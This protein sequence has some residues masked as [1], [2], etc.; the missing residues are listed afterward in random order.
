MNI[1][2]SEFRRKRKSII[3]WSIATSLFS[4]TILAVAPTLIDQGQELV[5]LLAA[6]P[7]FGEILGIQPE[8]MTSLA[9]VFSMY[10]TMMAI[11]FAIQAS[12]YGFSL[13]SVEETDLTADFLLTKPVRRVDII[14][15][16]LLASLLALAITTLVFTGITVL[17]VLPIKGNYEVYYKALV[18][19]CLSSF[20]IQ[21]FFFSV[22]VIVSLCM[23]RIKA[24][25]P[26]SMGLSFGL[27]V[28]NS[29][30][31]TLKIE[32]MSYLSPFGYFDPAAIL[33]EG[34]YNWYNFSLNAVIV[35]VALSVSYILYQKRD[36][37]SL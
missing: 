29:F 14:T 36:I 17:S 21:L 27:F 13:V 11:C 26:L 4:A 19:M 1:F 2:I 8:T 12:N 9:G 30:A 23:K 34:T 28:V 10:Y 37:K 15:A 18:L 7:A 24:V 20:F 22:G 31:R 35:I 32:F 3:I 25:L 6:M 16:K 33:R 5:K